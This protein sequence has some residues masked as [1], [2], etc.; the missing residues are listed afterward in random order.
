MRAPAA[1]LLAVAGITVFAGAIYGVATTT[2]S[3]L[4]GSFDATH[5]TQHADRSATEAAWRR[6]SADHAAA[7]EA[8]D[9]LTGARKEKCRAQARADA[10]RAA[11][12][13]RSR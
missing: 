11:R 13:D 2:A 6:A 12:R 5:S 10:I 9:S 4:A 8:C 3:S 1:G 7:R